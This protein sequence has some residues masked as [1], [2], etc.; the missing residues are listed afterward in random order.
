MKGTKLK[1]DINNLICES[2]GKSEY[3]IKLHFVG[4]NG[5]DEEEVMDALK[6]LCFEGVIFWDDLTQDEEYPFGTTKTFFRKPIINDSGFSDEELDDRNKIPYW[7]H[8]KKCMD[9]LKHSWEVQN[10]DAYL[11]RVYRGFR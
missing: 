8:L 5:E 9:T 1:R 10:E 6:D 4:I 2:N 11:D 7:V 3:Q